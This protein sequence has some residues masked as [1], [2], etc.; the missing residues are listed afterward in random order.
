[1]LLNYLTRLTNGDRQRAEDIVQE[2]LIRAWRNPQARNADG[3]WSRGWIFTVA[4]RIVIDQARA[5]TVRPQELPDEHVEHRASLTEDPIESLLDAREIRAALVALPERLRA[6]LVEI[7]YNERTVAEVA[8]ILD[9]PAGTVK[10]RTFY[11]LRALRE[12]LISRGFD[13]RPAASTSQKERVTGQQA[14]LPAPEPSGTNN[15]VGHA[16]SSTVLRTDWDSVAGTS[17]AGGSA[18]E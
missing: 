3:Q 11:A 5:A 15:K 10:S 2:V 4:K 7:Y 12:A 17:E 8:E 1:M 18:H 9:V 16:R 13:V 14:A 6:T